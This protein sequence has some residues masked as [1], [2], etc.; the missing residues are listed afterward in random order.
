MKKL[1]VGF[2]GLLLVGAGCL[3]VANKP[4]DGKWKLAFDLPQGWVMVVPYEASGEGKVKPVSDGVRRNDSEVFLQSSNQPI[5]FTSGGPCKEGAATEGTVISVSAIDSHRALPKN[6]EDLKNGF[7]R[8]KLCE[9]GGE[10]QIG[11]A[12]NY[13]YYLETETG[14]YSFKYNGDAKNV[15]SIIKSA[16]MV[17]HFTDLPSVEVQTQ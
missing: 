14:N 3:P 10:C 1:L 5:C 2:L 11:N 9:D 4:V 6:R 8:V 17:T 15:E 13:E 7:S 16:K 12:G